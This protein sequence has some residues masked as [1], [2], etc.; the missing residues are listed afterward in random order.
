M[1][2]SRNK[3]R[4]RKGESNDSPEIPD[5][6]RGHQ[7]HF[8]MNRHYHKITHSA[9]ASRLTDT[10]TKSLT[11]QIHQVEQ[12]LSQK[13]TIYNYIKT[14]RH[15]HK[16]THS[17]N[18]IRTNTLSQNHT[19]YR[20]EQTPSQNHTLQLHQDEHTEKHTLQLHQDKKT[21]SQIT[22][23]NYLRTNRHYHKIT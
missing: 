5:T 6:K 4:D 2:R 9:T 14:I 7:F 22:H 16:I 17:K 19:L 1:T 20:S 13:N 8:G 18:Y 10:I 15:Y 11:L 23:Y 21:P 3:R 12:T